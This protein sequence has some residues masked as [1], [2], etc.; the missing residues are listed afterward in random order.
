MG[1]QSTLSGL[2]CM[3][4]WSLNSRVRPHSDAVTLSV[5]LLGSWAMYQLLVGV[6]PW[7]SAV[8]LFALV[9][10]AVGL[11]AWMC[12]RSQP[13][14]WKR[15]LYRLIVV[16][17]VLRAV[18]WAERTWGDPSLRYSFDWLYASGLCVLGYAQIACGAWPGLTDAATAVRAAL[19]RHPGRG[20]H[21]GSAR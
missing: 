17:M 14:A 10:L 21:L 15:L 13:E 11:A 6:E 7:G 9:D 2:L 12:W 3:A 4:A 8:W 5:A 16:Q 20:P 1:A 18:Y 19:S